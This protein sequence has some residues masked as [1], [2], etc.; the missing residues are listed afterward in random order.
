M[1]SLIKPIDFLTSLLQHPQYNDNNIN[2]IV[3]N[4]RITKKLK[5]FIRRNEEIRKYKNKN[6]L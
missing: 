2:N 6:V 4:K 3:I 5:D 1:R